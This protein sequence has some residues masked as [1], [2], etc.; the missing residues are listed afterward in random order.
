MGKGDKP[1][2]ASKLTGIPHEVMSLFSGVYGTYEKV[3]P[4]GKL[5][6]TLS[7][8]IVAIK[9]K[10]EYIFPSRIDPMIVS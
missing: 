10:V 4:L 3:T 5:S 1:L 9:V 8:D 7:S 6:P 2:L